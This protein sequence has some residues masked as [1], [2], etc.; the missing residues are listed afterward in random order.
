[1]AA[2]AARWRRR[3]ANNQAPNFARAKQI[4]RHATDH[5]MGEPAASTEDKTVVLK[6]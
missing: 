5:I 2:A 1:M 6:T 3:Q 4:R